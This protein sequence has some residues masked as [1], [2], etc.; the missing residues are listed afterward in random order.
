VLLGGELEEVR[1]GLE[2][3]REEEPNSMVTAVVYAVDCDVLRV[4]A[5]DRIEGA[6][7]PSE[8][9]T[10]SEW[11]LIPPL[12]RRRMPLTNPKAAKARRGSEAIHQARDEFAL[13]VW[14]DHQSDH[15]RSKDDGAHYGRED[16]C[17][18]RALDAGELVLNV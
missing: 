18:K 1:K 13:D 10:D 2:K 17:L 6:N 14:D 15:H 4:V 16:E 9:R 11:K 12:S 8:N 7:N 3:A 5:S